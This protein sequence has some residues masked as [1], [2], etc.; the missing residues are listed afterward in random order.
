MLVRA[1]DRPS[2]PLTRTMFQVSVRDLALDPLLD[3]HP[4]FR[5]ELS[6]V[7]SEVFFLTRHALV[8]SLLENKP[9]LDYF[10]VQK[11]NEARVYYPNNSSPLE[12]LDRCF[13]DNNGSWTQLYRSE[14]LIA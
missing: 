10:D 14:G 12:D 11:Y 4:S 13:I 6:S 9:V 2:G 3:F 5:A 7:H 8:L 1:L